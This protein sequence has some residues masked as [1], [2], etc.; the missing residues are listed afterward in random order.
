LTCRI[1]I[2][3][4]HE[5]AA[6]RWVVRSANHAAVNESNVKLKFS[7][8]GHVGSHIIHIRTSE[9]ANMKE[10]QSLLN[11]EDAIIREVETILTKNNFLSNV[12]TA[13]RLDTLRKKLKVIHQKYTSHPFYHPYGGGNYLN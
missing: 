2:R 6:A 8:D 12:K 1:R 13:K 5:P 3:T 10:F 7:V 11:E 9:G 4:D